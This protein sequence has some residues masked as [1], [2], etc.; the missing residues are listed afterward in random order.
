MRSSG[1]KKEVTKPPKER[2]AAPVELDGNTVM[3][4]AERV[5]AERAILAELI[6]EPNQ[7]AAKVSAT[8]L[9]G[10]HFTGVRA[11]IFST[12]MTAT[13]EGEV[14]R[15]DLRG[16]ILAADVDQEAAIEFDRIAAAAGDRRGGRGITAMVGTLLDLCAKEDERRTERDSRI[17]SL[18]E[19]V[20]QFTAQQVASD[21]APVDFIWDQAIPAR[22]VGVLA[23]PGGAGKSALTVGLAI[24][25]ALG[26][27]YLGRGTKEGTTLFLTAED[28]LEDYRR[29]IAA[30]RVSMLDFDEQRVAK[31][32]LILDLVGMLL[33]LI[34]ADGRDY[35]PADV[36]HDVVE[37]IRERAP[38][39]D[40]IVIETASRMGGDESNP[41]AAALVCAAEVLARELEAAVM[42]VSH[43]SKS[44][45]REKARDAYVARGGSAIVDNGRYAITLSNID[46]S[47]ATTIVPGA[48]IDP[49]PD[50]LVA[51]AIPKV[52]AANV[53]PVAI[54]QRVST[55][56]G[57]VLKEVA[58]APTSGLETPGH[59]IISQ[60]LMELAARVQASGDTLTESK[61]SSGL[62]KVIKGLKKSDVP[63][64]VLR[65]VE[66]G[67]LVKMPRKGSGGG[68]CLLPGCLSAPDATL[69]PPEAPEKEERSSLPSPN[70]G[71]GG[72]VEVRGDGCDDDRGR[73]S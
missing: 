31:R 44:A 57:L 71:G 15:D 38:E 54:L 36:V 56:W 26:R 49:E 62:Y 17:E 40:L 2:S 22:K 67:A 55:R 13:S 45:A 32:I 50:G 65:A 61:L 42:I 30:H 69:S 23:G 24:A 73:H 29:K 8:P 46:I 4:R 41:A 72:G 39:A 35:A 11:I 68:T 28:D 53:Q 33:R 58:S 5:G 21:P 66:A 64:A 59:D 20:K 43:V 19:R 14:S 25:R 18:A 9:G 70:G 47:E 7:E 6:R 3:L 27:G 63:R 60:R 51:L 10:K 1:R 37:A 34:R 48:V 16:A 12:V 52:N